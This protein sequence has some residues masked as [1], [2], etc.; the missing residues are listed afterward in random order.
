VKPIVKWAGGKSK[1]LPELRTRVPKAI[2]TYVEPFMGGAALFFSLA[3]ERPFKRAR[4]GDKNEDL[5]ACYRAV[6][7]TVEDVIAALG[8]YKYDR[9]VYYRARDQDPRKLNDPA[10]AAR[11]IFL[12]RTCY[13]GLWRV[14]S[15]GK[16]NVPFGRYTNPKI[17][18]PDGLREA[19]K[20]LAGVDV[21]LS[22]FD[23]M[24]RD[25]SERD[26][27]YFDPP[28][29]PVSKT[30]DFTAYSADGF[31][32]ADQERLVDRMR[33]LKKRGVKALL[34]NADTEETRQLYREFRT[35]TV[36]MP[37]SIN[38]DASK[39]GDIGELLVMTWNAR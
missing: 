4:L 23:T 3:S 35:E 27:V 8:P 11:L 26:F 37:R 31:D 33:V 17:C 30:A 29:V 32:R 34:S 24:T 25:L 10:R 15:K 38:R 36:L 1:L 14:N 12:N 21:Q 6:R 19:A 9:D 7:D 16:F 5:V 18:D 20:L 28:Y 13:N 2:D 39:R 22:D